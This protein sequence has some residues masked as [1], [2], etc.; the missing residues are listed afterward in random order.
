MHYYE[1]QTR[2]S[3]PYGVG[4]MIGKDGE[5]YYGDW[6]AGFR[7]GTGL[8]KWTKDGEISLRSM[9]IEEEMVLTTVRHVK[10]GKALDMVFKACLENKNIDTLWKDA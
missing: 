10:S 6:I 3:Q 7:T 8:L 2:N 5:E 1:G 9:T 4:T